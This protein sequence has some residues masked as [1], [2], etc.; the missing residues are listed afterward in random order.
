MEERQ[1]SQP[2]LGS[3][4]IKTETSYVSNEPLS[5]CSPGDRRCIPAL[6]R[7]TEGREKAVE[8]PLIASLYGKRP[9]IYAWSRSR[10]K[11][12]AN[13]MR[14]VINY[15]RCMNAAAQSNS[16]YVFTVGGL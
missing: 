3:Y 4:D 14:F 11:V 6:T 2:A 12:N 1:E 16:K 8:R 10:Y 9:L 15:N 5:C 13:S 7:V